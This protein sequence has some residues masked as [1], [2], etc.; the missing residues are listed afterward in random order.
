MA[1]AS[2]RKGGRGRAGDTVSCALFLPQRS[3]PGS[4]SMAA[5]WR[6]INASVCQAGGVMIAPVVSD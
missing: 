6:P 2:E 5:A 4:V 1:E 3:V